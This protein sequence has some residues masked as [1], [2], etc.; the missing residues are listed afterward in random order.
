MIFQLFM[1]YT[2]QKILVTTFLVCKHQKCVI[3]MSLSQ[4]TAA[5]RPFQVHATWFDLSFVSFAKMCDIHKFGRPIVFLS[6][7]IFYRIDQYTHGQEDYKYWGEKN[8]IIKY[9]PNLYHKFEFRVERVQS[10]REQIKFAKTRLN[11]VN[12][13]NFKDT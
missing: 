2:F 9:I 6:G 4:S 7:F 11:N 5:H 8:H 1:G 10:L 12:G 3:F 13:I